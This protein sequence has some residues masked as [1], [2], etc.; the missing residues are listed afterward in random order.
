MNCIKFL[1]I[2]ASLAAAMTGANA[3][4]IA[5]DLTQSG[6]SNTISFTGLE[7]G[8]TYDLGFPTFEYRI[9]FSCIG[10]TEVD[11][12]KC[13]FV[14]VN[15]L[16]S[17][18]FSGAGYRLSYPDFGSESFN[19]NLTE[20]D[21]YTYADFPTLV[22]GAGNRSGTIT[23]NGTNLISIIGT[24]L[25]QDLFDMIGI[26]SVTSDGLTPVII[27][28]LTVQSFIGEQLVTPTI[29]ATLV[30][31]TFNLDDR[32]TLVQGGGGAGSNADVPLP[33]A[34]PLFAGAIGALAVMR[35]RRK[36]V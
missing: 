27:P 8:V 20:F 9:D 26:R 11:G 13:A 25:D 36:E 10:G 1:T 35:R 14:H 31:F 2:A 23:I 18:V 19:F 17:A 34:L 4:P 28:S 5:I 7:D 15:S 29:T 24:R 12:K 21:F 22:T 16:V 3:T 6:A 33:A 30:S 32:L